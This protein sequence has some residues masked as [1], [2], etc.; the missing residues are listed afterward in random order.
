[1][2]GDPAYFYIDEEDAQAVWWIITWIYTGCLPG[3]VFAKDGSNITACLRLIHCSRVFLLPDLTAYARNHLH[4]A[5]HKMM[6]E[7][8]T[9]FYEAEDSDE[10]LD[11]SELRGFFAGVR[12]V[13]EEEDKNEFACEQQYFVNVVKGAHFWPLLDS[14]FQRM[15]QD[16][17][18]FWTEVMSLQQIAITEGSHW[19]YLK[20]EECCKCEHS[21]W[22]FDDLPRSTH[23]AKLK[24]VKGKCEATCN[25]C[26]GE[27]EERKSWTELWKEEERQLLLSP[28]DE[29]EEGSSTS[30]D[31]DTAYLPTPSARDEEPNT[32]ALTSAQKDR[33]EERERDRKWLE[34]LLK[35][36]GTGT[37]PTATRDMLWKKI[38]EMRQEAQGRS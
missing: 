30:N 8:Q 13:Y 23:W 4:H 33:D 10:Q 28:D 25:R 19:P 2:F 35:I 31:S 38:D 16:C 1:M 7:A 36:S 22:K 20:P 27:E 17:P 34:R 11:V 15:T 24:L 3:E 29:G 6:I 5:L 9:A 32:D 21:P 12:M 26:T 18:H 37:I 14:N